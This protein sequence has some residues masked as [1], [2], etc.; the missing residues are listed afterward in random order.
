MIRMAAQFLSARPTSKELGGPD[1]VQGAVSKIE[2]KL[3]ELTPNTMILGARKRHSKS[4]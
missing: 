1:A 3:I 4:Y 2:L